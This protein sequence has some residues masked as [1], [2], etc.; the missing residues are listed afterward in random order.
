MWQRGWRLVLAVLCCSSAALAAPRVRV[1][2]KG[3]CPSR[4]DVEAALARFT[5]V[6]SAGEP[7]FRVVVREAAGGGASLELYRPDGGRAFERSIHSDDC[8]SLAEAFALI[9]RAHFLELG[10]ELPAEDA[11]PPSSDVESLPSTGEVAPPPEA[12]PSTAKPADATL[13]GRPNDAGRDRRGTR[14]PAAASEWR[15]AVGVGLGARA[16][17]PDWRIT[18]ALHLELE[19]LYGAFAARAELSADLGA[20]SSEPHPVWRQSSELLL[21]GGLHLG[22][23]TWL[24]VRGGVGVALGWA[25]A[26]ELADSSPAASWTPVGLLGLRG[27]YGPPSFVVWLEVG[28]TALVKR[29]RYVVDPFGDVGLGPRW[30]L[31][32]LLGA[33]FGW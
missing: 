13:E 1:E 16:L 20:E 6:A 10:L 17:V 3:E 19:G 29:D 27:G 15:P 31:Q 11:S 4:K 8:A 32:T 25:R 28:G 12:R 23:R 5:E 14:A 22:D 9:V 18:P 2:V 7:H 30:Y 24:D 33:R 26:N 21:S